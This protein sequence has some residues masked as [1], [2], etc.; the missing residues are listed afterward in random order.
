MVESICKFYRGGHC[1]FGE[2]CRKS[3]QIETCSA[4]PFLN[5]DCDRRHPLC[6]NF[7]IDMENVKFMIS[8][9]TYTKLDWKAH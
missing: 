4:F 1:K 3:H 5:D 6:V 8:A 9:P 7:I 2:T